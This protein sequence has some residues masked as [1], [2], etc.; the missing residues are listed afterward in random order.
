MALPKK[1]MQHAQDSIATVANISKSFDESDL[2]L[3]ILSVI[4]GKP[5][6]V[7]GALF[8]RQILVKESLAR[9]KLRHEKVVK[10]DS[11]HGALCNVLPGSPFYSQLSEF[12]TLAGPGRTPDSPIAITV[13]QSTPAWSVSNAHEDEERFKQLSVQTSFGISN[14]NTVASSSDR[15]GYELIPGKPV[16]GIAK[17]LKLPSY[18]MGPHTPV[19]EFCGRE[20]VLQ[21]VRSALCSTNELG[22][23]GPLSGLRTFAIYG[24][25]GMGKTQVAV[26]FAYECK[27]RKEFDAIFWIQASDTGKLAKSFADIALK[28]GL[29]DNSGDQVVSRDLV[30]EWLSYP[31]HQIQDGAK[32]SPP[33]SSTP[34][35]L[36]IFDNADEL[37]I[38]RDYWPISGGGAILVT[39]RDPLAKSQTYFQSDAGIELNPFNHEDALSLVR[40]LTGYSKPKDYELSAAIVKR[41]SYIPLAIN[42]MAKTIKRRNMSLKEFIRYYE[43]AEMRQ[44]F[45]KTVIGAPASGMAP[46]TIATVWSLDDLHPPAARLF[47]VISFM[48]PDQI[49]ES[50]LTDVGETAASLSHYPNSLDSFL[51][52]RSELTGSSLLSRNVDTEELTTHRIIQDTNRLQMSQDHFVLVF[53]I[54][55]QLLYRAWHFSEFDWEPTRWPKCEPVIAH[56]TY[57]GEVYKGARDVTIEPNT[58]AKLARLLMEAGWYYVERGLFKQSPPF[59]DLAEEVCKLAPQQTR[60]T[61]ADICYCRAELGNM[62]NDPKTALPFAKQYLSLISEHDP[63][64]WRLPQA[65]NIMAVL[66]LGTCDYE[67]SISHANLA[68]HLYG[69]LPVPEYVAFAYINKA[70]GLL[71]TGK[72]TEAEQVLESYLQGQPGKERAAV[73]EPYK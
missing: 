64:G 20:D 23:F 17:R 9:T 31:T 72:S 18:I 32:L 16:T 54:V 45:N 34:K 15:S 67:G 7:K 22:R 30:L 51:L 43:Q 37:S 11:T 27:A 10:T 29:E 57:L 70:Y 68:I 6:K 73:S 48:D 38:L 35:W 39:S 13:T 61:F 58:A 50:L 69:T 46:R 52:A 65:H 12:L 71:L 63:K 28:L 33:A 3:D 49:Q 59:F 40:T 66:S 5:T 21:Q 8:K 25:G 42:Q 24:A 19:P 62:E 1:A 2:D 41:L 47:D 56:V 4:E 26:T 55:C 60:I 44:S 14:I 53:D 36:L